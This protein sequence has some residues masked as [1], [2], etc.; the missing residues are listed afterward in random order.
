MTATM[1]LACLMAAATSQAAVLVTNVRVKCIQQNEVG[2][3][4]IFLKFGGQRFNMGNFSNGTDYTSP[5]SLMVNQ[6]LPFYQEMWEDDGAHWYDGDDHWQ[7]FDRLLTAYGPY[8]Y[9]NTDTGPQTHNYYYWF[10]LNAI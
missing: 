8:G 2:Q 1:A 5:N 4:E 6:S 3:D 7:Y 10:T 9:Q